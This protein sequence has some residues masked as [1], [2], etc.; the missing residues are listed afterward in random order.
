MQIVN[1]QEKVELNSNLELEI[2]KLLLTPPHEEDTSVRK[3]AKKLNHPAS[4][5][6]YYL[7]KM[8]KEGILIK[9]EFA[10]GSGYY[11]PNDIFIYNIEVTKGLL[12]KIAEGVESPSEEKLANCIRGFLRI[13][14]FEC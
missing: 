14:G 13:N 4:H 6:F 3:I 1:L 5:I 11:V 9:E 10:R 2:L 7:K 12:R 8:H